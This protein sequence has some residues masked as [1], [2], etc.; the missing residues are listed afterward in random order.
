MRCYTKIILEPSHTMETHHAQSSPDRTPLYIFLAFLAGIALLALGLWFYQK[1]NPAPVQQTNINVTPA[2]AATTVAPTSPVVVT[3]PVAVTPLPPVGAV[4]L[5]TNFAIKIDAASGYSFQ[6][7]KTIGGL[8]VTAQQWPPK[9]SVQTAPSDFICAVGKTNDGVE[10]SQEKV[11][12]STICLTAREDG[13][14][15]SI[16][17][18][19]DFAWVVPGLQNS[20]IVTL[21]FIVKAP[22]SCMVYSGAK[23]AVCNKE[24]AEFSVEKLIQQ[25]VPT[26]KKM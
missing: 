13:A 7:P 20:N 14:A 16:Y 3:A 11:G 6:Y 23:R 24:V 10:V 12:T 19:Y 8:Y 21:S 1:S 26:V 22:S 15:G 17:T 4:I 18:T 25:I 9:I 2:P 5:P